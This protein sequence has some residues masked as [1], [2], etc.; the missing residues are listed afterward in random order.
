MM[1]AFDPKRTFCA[2]GR[3]SALGSKAD[4]LESRVLA[5]ASALTFAVDLSRV[6]EVDRDEPVAA[7]A[8]WTAG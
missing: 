7:G 5:D 8:G 6:Q 2:P 3:M 4:M 1:S